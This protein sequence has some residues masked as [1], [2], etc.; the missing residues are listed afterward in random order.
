MLKRA[1]VQLAIAKHLGAS[2][3]ARWFD[4]IRRLA[5]S[6]ITDVVSWDAHGVRV[7]PSAQLSED[8]RRAIHEVVEEETTIPQRHGDPIVKRRV[9]V[10]LHGK[11]EAL[12]LMGRALQVK[13][14]T[15]GAPLQIGGQTLNLTLVQ[16]NESRAALES[17]ID[18]LVARLGAH[19]VP[20]GADGHG[21]NA[22]A[23]RLD[24][25]GP[26]GAA[27]AA[28]GVADLAGDGGARLGQDPNGRG[29]DP[30]AGRNGAGPADRPGQ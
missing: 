4:E 20:R 18:R 9:R 1:S 3:P 28:R 12:T 27:D 8:A 6:D 7:R 15:E 23:L 16:I 26:A 29:G 19:G 2:D 13:G 30:P 11:V 21:A 10:R 25:L 22:P 24:V 5:F 17:R 14:L